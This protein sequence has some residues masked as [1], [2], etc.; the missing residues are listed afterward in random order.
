VAPADVTVGAGV[1]LA[2]DAHTR[3]VTLT[4][5]VL[6]ATIAEDTEVILT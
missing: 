1:D 6:D 4:G 2:L 3:D 5:G